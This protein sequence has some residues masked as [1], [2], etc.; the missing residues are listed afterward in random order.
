MRYWIETDT[1]K[2]IIKHKTKEPTVA[3]LTAENLLMEFLGFRSNAK[4]EQ[5]DS[6]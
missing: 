2:G 1:Q 6:F 3:M 4:P 5:P